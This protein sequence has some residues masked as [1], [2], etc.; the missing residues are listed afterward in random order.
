MESFYGSTNDFSNP[1]N[2]FN[3]NKSKMKKLILSLMFLCFLT[4]TKATCPIVTNADI[5]AKSDPV[6]PGVNKCYFLLRFDW[7]NPYNQ[8]GSIKIEIKCLGTVVFSKCLTTPA[9]GV[10][11]YEM[12][13]S[14]WVICDCNKEPSYT[15]TPRYN[16]GSCGGS[17]CSVILNQ[18]NNINWDGK[19]I[20]FE[21]LLYLRGQQLPVATSSPFTPTVVGEYYNNNGKSVYVNKL[22]RQTRFIVYDLMGREIKQIVYSPNAILPKRITLVGSQY[23]IFKQIQ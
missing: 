23:F 9:Y 1:F 21:G 6:A 12:P 8:V 5:V 4:I 18:S 13:Q 17:A 10:G 19:Q 3:N 15:L 16:S 14:D 20:Y 11:H 7:R 2:N 22:N